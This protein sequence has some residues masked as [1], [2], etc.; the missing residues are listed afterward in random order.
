V[1]AAGLEALKQLADHAA[2]YLHFAEEE[3]EKEGFVL[4]AAAALGS[5]PPELYMASCSMLRIQTC[6]AQS[7]LSCY[8]RR[9]A[10]SPAS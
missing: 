9:C 6:S 7:I 10:Q 4:F 1:V 2:C 8:C 5:K 3:E